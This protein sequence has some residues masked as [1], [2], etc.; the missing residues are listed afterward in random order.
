MFIEFMVLNI[1]LFFVFIMVLF[2]FGC[3]LV[4]NRLLLKYIFDYFNCLFYFNYWF[5]IVCYMCL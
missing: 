3:F 2:N 5:I 1:R 4:N